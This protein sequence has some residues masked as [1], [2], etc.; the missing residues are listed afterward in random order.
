ADWHLVL[1][2]DA[3][4][5]RDLIPA[6]EKALD[7]VPGAATMSPYMGKQQKG[8]TAALAA[9]GRRDVSWV[10]LPRIVWGVA[11]AAPVYTIRDMLKWCR[12]HS[13]PNDDTRISVYYRDAVAF[14]AWYT[15]PSLV[16]HAQV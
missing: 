13:I 16:D 5:C 9:K 7:Q 1:Q 8:A 15:W 2:D 6:L 14:P 10:R 12:G 4:V 3:V 11:M